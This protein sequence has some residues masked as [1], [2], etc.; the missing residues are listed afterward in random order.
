[1]N[2]RDELLTYLLEREGFKRQSDYTIPRRDSDDASLRLSFAQERFWF[3]DQFEHA[4]P[5]YNGCK[6]VRLT[7]ELN[8]Q[9][10][11]ECLNLIVRRHEVLRTTYPAPDG[12]P[13][14][15]IAASCSVEIAE[16]DL[17]YLAHSEIP[18]AIEL[19]I[20]KEWLQPIVLSEELPIRARLIRIDDGQ[21]L[22][23][24]TLHQIVFD[25]QSVAIFFRE[26]WAAYEAKLSGKEP[27]LAA[28]PVQYADYASW[29]RHRISSQ[30]FRS[31]REYWIQRLTGTLPFLNLPTDYPRPQVQ[32]FEGSRLSIQLPET[33]QLKLKELSRENGVTLFMT[34]LAA[35]KTL[36][37]RYT[38]QEDLIV[39]CPMLNR[40]LPEIEN[41]LGSF[42][43]TVALRTNYAGSPSFRESLRRVRETCVNAFAHQDFPFEKLVEELQLQR[44]VGRNPIF[45]VMF[46]F[47][48]NSVPALD[49][50][51]LRSEIV[52]TEGG[53]TKF[54]LT[55]SLIDTE[56]GIGG[57]IEY[58]TDLFNRDTIERM[59]QHFQTLLESIAIDP[60]QSITM[61][62]IL[63]EAERHQVLVEWNHT[64]ANYP[65][66]KC[67]HELFEAQVERT[68]DAVAVRYEGQ[69]LTYLELN[70]CSN[71][72]AHYLISIGVGAEKLVGIGL[73]RSITM[74]VGL[75]GVLKAGGS[76]VPLE[77]SYPKERVIFM[78]KEA[79]LSLVLTEDR[80]KFDLEGFDG[81]VVCL[82]SDWNEIAKQSMDNLAPATESDNLAYIMFTS[83]STGQ[84]KGVMITHRAIC[85]RLLWTQD[86]YQLI[87]SDRVLHK[88]PF[89]FDVSVWEIFWPLLNGASLFVARPGGH[90]DEKY[91]LDLIADKQI[92]VVHFVPSML[93]IFLA[94]ADVERCRTLR[95]VFCSGEVLPLNLQERFF[96][97]SDA[98]LH[99][100]YGPTEA[101]IDVTSWACVRG[102]KLST[103]P[104]G[105]PIANSQ[106]YILDSRREPVPVG[107]SGELYI[108]GDGLARGYRNRP[109]LTEEKFIPNP[110]SV[111]PDSR[112]YRSGDL[113][114]YR[115]DGNIE[116]LG[117]ND[118][119]VKIRGHRIE[120]GEIEA[121]LNQIPWVRESVIVARDRDESDEKELSGYIVSK[122][123]SLRS[124]TEV[125]RFLQEKLP[126]F[127]IPSLF[128]FLDAL[129][130]TPNGKLD[131]NALPAPDGE[132]PNLDQG[133]VEPRT[134]IE[135]LIAQVWREILKLDNIGVHDNFFELGG[136]SL[137]AT[138][139]V[140]RLRG[141]LNV[142]VALRKLFELA[143]VAGLGQHIEQL[144][145]SEFGTNSAPI[146]PADRAQPLPL[147]FSQRRLW[148]LQKVDA[149][150]SAYNIPAS[151]RFKGSLDCAALEHALN[152]MIARHEVLRSHV[153]E[154][155]GQ[156]R[157]EIL[158]SLRIALPVIDLT[159]LPDERAD[160]EAK[161]LSA[162][163]ARHLHD[164]AIAP[165]MRAKLVKLADDDHVLIL[166]FHHIIADGSSLVI[167]YKEFAA[168]Y[169]SRRDGTTISLPSL[170]I[171]YADY[172]AWQQEWLK[173]ASFDAHLDYW[174]RQLTGLPEPCGL[175]TDFDRHPS[176][177]DRG[178]RAALELSDELTSALKQLSRQQSVTMFM[179]LFA[180]F[181]ILLSRISGQ[182][183][184]VTGSTIAGRNHPE[185]DGLL[186]F[187][188]NALPLRIDLSGD[189][190]F[191]ALL[192]RAREVCLDAYTHQEVPF[193]KLVETL[194]PPRE[195][196]RNP[197][198]D[199]LFNIAD[200]SERTL[201]LTGCEVSKLAQVDPAAKFDIVLYAPE[202]NG[203]IELAIVYNTELFRECRITA[204]L[205]QF[206][207]LL[208]QVAESPELPISQ[209]SLV[210]DAARAVLPDPKQALDD[211][212]QGAIHELFAEQARRAP[213][214][215]AIVDAEQ[216]WSYS[217]L[218]RCAN[219]LA[220]HLIASSIQSNDVIAIYADRSSSL[221]LALLGTL[222]AG[223][224]FLILDPAYPG[225]RN[226]DY[227][228][229]A[230]PKGW[231]QLEGNGELPN[232]LVNCLDRLQLR[233]RM[234]VPN[235]KAEILEQLSAFADSEPA[236][237]VTADTLAYIAFTSGSTGEPKGVV[238]RHGPITHFLPWQRN[239]FG[240]NEMDRFAMLS[241]LA[242]SHLHRD[243]FTALSLGATLYIPSPM[244]ARSPNRLPQWL[245]QHAITLLHLTPALGELLLTG[246]GVRLPS[247]RRVFFGGDILTTETVA[248]IQ[249]LAPNATVGSFYGATETQRAVGYFEIP[250]DSP[251][252]DIAAVKTIPL[253]RG[254]E[255]VQ[256]LVLNRS[257]RLAGV[258]EIGEIFVR[259]PHLAKGYIGDEERTERTF[260][261]SPFTNNPHDRMYRTGE[262]GRFTSDGNV[263]WAGGNDRRV[264]I[265]GF[266]IELAEIEIALKQHPTVKDAA[267]V[268]QNFGRTESGNPK[269]DP[270]IVAYV[271]ADEESQS[272]ADLL[273]SYLITR[274]P[275]YMVPAHFVILPALPLSPNGK[276]D[277]RSLPAPQFASSVVESTAPRNAVENKL[278]EIFSEVLGR[279]D[280]S[281]E[282]NFFR[283]G[284]HS[285]LAARAAVRLGDAF[286]V[287]LDLSAFLEN[288]TVI[289]LAKKVDS[290]RATGQ[291]NSQSDKDQ[292]E[293]FDL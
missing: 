198:F 96:A 172:A 3:L 94:L 253:G 111:N 153:R 185:T 210:T 79:Q 122:Q 98:A 290:L 104:I 151:F 13:I 43:N 255:D 136:H 164:L 121:T 150:L 127:M 182:E 135:E 116:F 82:D 166:N 170:P 145:H 21:H 115:A 186:G 41:L 278:C 256:L 177:S 246:G 266:R 204:L 281:I 69:Q 276:V 109:E 24:L 235:S 16:T 272:L 92:T 93:N 213:A 262:L 226:S 163:D 234:N 152:E 65:K 47:Q 113:A 288:P 91:L 26:L 231:L 73:E 162:V 19:M 205:D 291:T 268:A 15:H 61:L 133:F 141:S 71:Q 159:R 215:L 223:A 144:R 181:N 72:L 239:A 229:I 51:E 270:G 191:V 81:D 193:E 38:A 176:Q 250:N 67:V 34:L 241:G 269:S 132:R 196:G 189:P 201:T 46:A 209:L 44:D 49:L 6:V 128:V 160:I 161:R 22:L 157:Q 244:E 119:Q 267:V 18:S 283:I 107:V 279:S 105:R 284:G 87:E 217:E 123:A 75:L 183:D 243:V 53:M 242:Y 228:R 206:A 146:A 62:P 178:A 39:G 208:A 203:R 169:E 76:Y 74:V 14:Q 59:A 55:F 80:L 225:A 101:A 84:P 110:F 8:V 5:V 45:Q 63:T 154:V 289:G 147:S 130:L 27:P 33:L 103:V 259:S 78:I 214:M 174:K 134:E 190:S 199:I 148:Y 221:V 143:T 173:S 222:K 224:A 100:L 86:A 211:S 10:L 114:K 9:V 95:H 48:N 99:N 158:P 85:N 248:S 254:I 50:A 120:L 140:A 175:P 293:E 7:G 263:E 17:K 68:P 155:D 102:S 70:H 36:L 11:A 35:F 233:C 23:I 238:C 275:N 142:D 156:P 42:V 257:Q 273:Q 282:D 184:I 285:L 139:V 29:Q 165:L 125:R 52:E 274:L 220:N 117:R 171:Q 258:G 197:I 30:T 207:T 287:D 77:P 106:I 232:E 240:L 37:Y 265:R 277:Y 252:R 20:Q 249:R 260:I 188:I 25:S 40:R 12:R 195:P 4:R 187:F 149:N 2:Q 180:T 88:T 57:H 292:R 126:D 264:N 227:L 90:Q 245:E 179:T 247:V 251:A 112:L 31:H 230:Q 66:D 286:G 192:K 194:R 237:I 212:W 64:I 83:G 58:S 168:L 54:D 32:S 167:F 202:V 271:G 97:R 89:S 200:I 108:G 60:D 1:L 129:P 137:L 216:T 56:H 28:L 219:R 138:R 131:R 124:Q 118:N 218:D 280:V 236:T 261:A